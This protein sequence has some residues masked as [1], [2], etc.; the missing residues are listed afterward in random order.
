MGNN[1]TVLE[2]STKLFIFQLRLRPENVVANCNALLEGSDFR[3]E[4]VR[5]SPLPCQTPAEASLY[6]HMHYGDDEG[7]IF[8]FPMATAGKETATL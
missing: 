8:A 5:K 7:G 4:L 1:D 6:D 3:L 2:E